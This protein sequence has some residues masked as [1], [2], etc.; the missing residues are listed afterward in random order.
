MMIYIIGQCT[1]EIRT[2][3]EEKERVLSDL[4][5]SLP[6]RELDA[7]ETRFDGDIRQLEDEL[8]DIAPEP[9]SLPPCLNALS[10]ECW[11]WHLWSRMK[12]YSFL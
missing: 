6:Y 11:H 1:K 9:H 10:F 7:M 3:K 5:N 2:K 4:M 12:L 8:E